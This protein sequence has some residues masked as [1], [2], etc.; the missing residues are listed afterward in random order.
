MDN[1]IISLYIATLVLGQFRR[2]NC[3]HKHMSTSERA[4]YAHTTNLMM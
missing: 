2:R 4:T 3:H 1:Y